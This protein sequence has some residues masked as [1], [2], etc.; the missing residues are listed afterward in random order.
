MAR[1]SS[2]RPEPGALLES[3]GAVDPAVRSSRRSASA[4]SSFESR[5][6]PRTWPITHR[7]AARPRCRRKERADVVARPVRLARAALLERVRSRRDGRNYRLLFEP[8]R[9]TILLERGKREVDA[10]ERTRLYAE[11]ERILCDEAPWAFEYSYRFYEV[12]QA[13]VR[14]YRMPTVWVN[15]LIPVWLDKALEAHARD[16]TRLFSRQLLGTLARG[17]GR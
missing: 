8:D 10:P 7:R 16:R 17:L 5:A 6:S 3:T 1:G 4:S 2:V 9:S 15:D 11:A 12:R 14:G 13:Y